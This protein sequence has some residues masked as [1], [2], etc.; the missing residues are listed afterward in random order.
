MQHY[1]GS[2]W[3]IHVYKYQ[4]FRYFPIASVFSQM[5]RYMFHLK[6][7]TDTLN[8][9][10]DPPSCSAGPYAQQVPMPTH[11]F[12]HRLPCRLTW[13]HT[14]TYTHKGTHSKDSPAQTHTHGPYRHSHLP[15]H[16]PRMFVLPASAEI[17]TPQMQINLQ[18]HTHFFWSQLISSAS[19]SNEAWIIQQDQGL[20]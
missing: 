2:S 3:L 20:P 9:H 6:L 8:R 11:T 12:I 13:V 19:L 16:A 17:R 5:Y 14:H 4:H 7:A 1:C 18:E 15:A 10:K